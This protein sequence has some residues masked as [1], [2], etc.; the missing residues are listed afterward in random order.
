MADEGLTAGVVNGGEV[1]G[2]LTGGIG[3]VTGHADIGV[4][5]AQLGDGTVKVHGDDF[6]LQA[7]VIG[8]VAA[9]CDVKAGQL[10]LVVGVQSVELIGSKVGAGNHGQLAV[11]DGFQQG[12]QLVQGHCGKI[13]LRYRGGG[14]GLIAG[15]FG[16]GIGGLGGGSGGSAGSQGQHQAQSQHHCKQLFHIHFS[17]SYSSLV[18]R[19]FV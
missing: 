8:N 15:G 14:G 11:V 1:H 3:G 17:F 16:G 6:Q 4:A 5:H 10:R 13:R 12:L 7:Q 18:R 9:Q 19:G 2:V